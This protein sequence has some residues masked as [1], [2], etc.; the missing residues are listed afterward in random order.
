MLDAVPDLLDRRR[1][2]DASGSHI[3]TRLRSRRCVSSGLS[4]S[5]PGSGVR[6]PDL[7]LTVISKACI[8]CRLHLVDAYDACKRTTSNCRFYVGY[9]LYSQ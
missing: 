3:D 5:N 9:P 6:G 1:R 2:D 8:L 7:G 4:Y